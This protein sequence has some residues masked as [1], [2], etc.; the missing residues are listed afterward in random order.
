[1]LKSALQSKN[2][3]IVTLHWL[4]LIMRSLYTFVTAFSTEC[5]TLK[6][7]SN[8][9][10]VGIIPSSSLS[11]FRHAVSRTLDRIE[12]GYYIYGLHDIS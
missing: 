1:M 5:Y 8:S 3:S 2:T 9:S 11:C 4:L 12:L 6:A 10:G 7:N